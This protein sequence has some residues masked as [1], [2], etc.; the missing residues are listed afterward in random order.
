MID[1][2]ICDDEK[3]FQ[4]KIEVIITR[5]MD[6]KGIKYNVSLFDNGED[7]L[8]YC[9]DLSH[10]VIIFLDINMDNIDGIETAKRIRELSPDI[11][12]VFVTAYIKYSLEGYKFNAI[13]YI[14]KGDKNFTQSIEESI[15]AILKD[16]DY[17]IKKMEFL[18]R[19]GKRE[20]SVDSIFYIESNLHT[21][22]FH[23][24][25]RKK[26]KYSMMSTLNEIE[27]KLEGYGFLRIHQSFLINLKHVKS[28]RTYIAEMK[29]GSKLPI[30]RTKYRIIKEA[31]V[32]YKGEI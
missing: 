21:V 3:I 32:E 19:E 7:L 20:L 1:I 14:I 29:D 2:A 24:I 9:S 18:F 23:V 17:G 26:H 15:D 11:Y 30:P 28:V 27:K 5:Y 4:D 12:I 22:I 8:R 31:Y 13:R 16:M 6:Q 25:G 10:Q